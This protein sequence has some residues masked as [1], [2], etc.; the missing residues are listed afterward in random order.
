M[1]KNIV[2]VGRMGQGKS[3]LT[4]ALIK[5]V[6][7]EKLHVFD[8]NGEYQNCVSHSHGDYEKFVNDVSNMNNTVNVFE[9]ATIFFN[10]KGHSK[11]LV[12]ILTRKR[13]KKQTNILL[14]HSLR[15]VPIY[16]L[17][18]IDVVHLLRTNDVEESIRLKFKDFGGFLETFRKAQKS[19]VLEFFTI[20]MQKGYEG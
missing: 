18:L 11:T 15:S 1:A 13:H 6:H 10:S 17:E 20:D 9:E 12:N 14:F 8:I 19:D 4:K 7:P 3:T 16:I 5:N 2:I